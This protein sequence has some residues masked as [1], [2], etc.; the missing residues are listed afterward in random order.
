MGTLLNLVRSTAADNKQASII[1]NLLAML[2]PCQVA[3]CVDAIQVL[4]LYE[5]LCIIY[6]MTQHDYLTCK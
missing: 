3:D 4:S 2:Q 6:A 1:N 5:V